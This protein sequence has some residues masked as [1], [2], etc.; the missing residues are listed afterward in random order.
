MSSVKSRTL[1]LIE[2]G[3]TNRSEISRM[4][5]KEFG[6]TNFESIRTQVRRVFKSY[7]PGIEKGSEL[8]EVDSS[9]VPYMWLKPDGKHSV[10][11]KNPNF[12]IE[13][14]DFEKIINAVIETKTPIVKIQKPSNVDIIDRLIWTDVHVGMDAS[15]NGLALY[16]AEWNKE[17]LMSRVKEMA[18][19]MLLNK[20]SD[21]LYIDELGDY[22][23]GYNGETT[24]GGHKLPQN[25]SN[26]EAFDAGLQA[27]IM[28]VDIL[29]EYYKYIVCHNICNDNHAGS[30]GYLVNSAFKSVVDLKYSNVEVVNH[31]RFISHYFVGDHCFII[32]HGKDAQHMKFGFKPVLDAR[33]AEKIDQYL[34]YNKIY[35]RAKYVEFSKG[36]SHQCMFDMATSDDFDYFNYPAFSPSSEWVQTNF[37][38]GKSGFV[39]QNF[40]ISSPTK[41]T[42]PYFFNI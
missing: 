20:K 11:V 14:I 35:E 4:L 3:M 32:T 28:L 31:K 23:D 19:Q 41:T 39:M 16:A 22:L 26:E 13:K 2:Q 29:K 6:T 38:K 7:N 15:R 18:H 1:E 21:I 40:S 10:F 34:K 42:T 17:I 12:N 33:N 27:K 24:R 25:M 8:A 5:C 36:D 30:F 37:K 9:N